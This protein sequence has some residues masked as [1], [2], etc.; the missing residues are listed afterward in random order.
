MLIGNTNRICTSDMYSRFA[1]R[2][3]PSEMNMYFA[4]AHRMCKSDVLIRYASWMFISVV[5]NGYADSIRDIEICIIWVTDMHLRNPYET[6]MCRMHVR[7][8]TPALKNT[9]TLER[10]LVWC[11]RHHL[12]QILAV[13]DPPQKFGYSFLTE[14]RNVGS[15]TWREGHLNAARNTTKPTRERINNPDSCF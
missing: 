14:I 10:A 9:Q 4:H 11:F 5:H 15:N 8:A 7:Y 2:I 6:Q 3:S 1:Y 13:W 12:G